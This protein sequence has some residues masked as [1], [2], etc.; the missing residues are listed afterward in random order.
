MRRR[1]FIK[2]GATLSLATALGKTKA[3]EVPT[4]PTNADG[5]IT[6]QLLRRD[7]PKWRKGV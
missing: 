7:D 1:T 5:S 2:A 6:F 4:Q 3:Q